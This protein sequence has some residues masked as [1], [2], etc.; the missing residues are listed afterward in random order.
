MKT[1]AFAAGLAVSALA[2]TPAI[3]AVPS[4]DYRADGA[5]A[6]LAPLGGYSTGLELGSEIAAYDPASRRIFVT[7]GAEVRLDVLD[8]RNLED[9]SLDTI[10]DIS[11]WGADLQSVAVS[12]GRVAI[13]IAADPA[14]WIPPTHARR[15]TR[16]APSRSSSSRAGP[17]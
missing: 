2:L 16:K 13:A 1:L 12:N 14:A 11:A 17:A 5:R 8:A 10:V 7:N 15:T 9:I 6:H 4:I 3:A